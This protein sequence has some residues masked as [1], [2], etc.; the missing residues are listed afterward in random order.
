VIR[1]AAEMPQLHWSPTDLDAG[2]RASIAAWTAAAG[3]AN[4]DPPR[5]LDVAQP[6][7]TREQ[8]LRT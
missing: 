2:Q 3:A 6:G 5:P 4:I 7:W 1:F 8:P